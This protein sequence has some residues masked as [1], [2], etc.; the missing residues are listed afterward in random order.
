MAAYQM[1]G[2]LLGLPNIHVL[3]YQISGNERIEV[4]IRSSLE[5]AL[6][7]ECHQIST[8]LHDTAES[9]TLRDLPIWDRQCWL[10][11]A[12][13]RF[14]CMHCGQTFVE[15]VPWRT[16]G[17]AYTVRYAQHIYE[18]TRQQDIAQIAQEEGLSQDTVRAIFE[19]G[20]KNA[21]PARL[22]AR[23]GAVPG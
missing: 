18:R 22:P 12:P 16:P 6:C 3:G 11:N 2:E 4:Q 1:L 23:K 7:P 9:Q 21:R 8:Q 20:A 5:A 10:R 19:R 15:R 13:R 14:A 17:L